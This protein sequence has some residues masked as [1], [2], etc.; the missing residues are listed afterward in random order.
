MADVADALITLP[1]NAKIRKMQPHLAR[2]AVCGDTL[3]PLVFRLLY[4]TR[5][6][7]LAVGF[8]RRLRSTSEDRCHP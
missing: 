4:S 8:V 2:Y 1:A 6:C 3:R 5:G 7:G